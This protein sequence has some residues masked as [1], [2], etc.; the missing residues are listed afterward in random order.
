[1]SHLSLGRI[2]AGAHKPVPNIY[3]NEEIQKE[4]AEQLANNIHKD[5]NLIISLQN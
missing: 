1:M 2:E 4:D 5:S 3:E